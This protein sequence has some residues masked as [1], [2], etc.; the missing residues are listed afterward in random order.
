[1]LD[2]YITKEKSDALKQELNNLK[3]VIRPDI[4]RRV[5]DA[6]ELGDLKENAEYHSARD[7]QSKI[8]SRIQEIESILKTS[9]LVKARK[10]DTIQIGSTVDVERIDKKEKE[11]FH[12]VGEEESDILN[13]KISYI[14]PVGAAI[15]GKKKGEK[16]V[17]KTPGGIIKYK[18]KKIS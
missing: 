17:V 4:I 13:S 6:R 8:E 14:S 1:M 18:I 2:H 16:A 7:E 12:I 15:L 5:S 9:K 10:S 11:T 3:T